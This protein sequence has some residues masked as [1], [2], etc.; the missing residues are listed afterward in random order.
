MENNNVIKVSIIQITRPSN[1]L[2]SLTI[3][4]RGRYS[5]I[6]LGFKN[7]GKYFFAHCF[8]SLKCPIFN[9][10]QNLKTCDEER[11]NY[12]FL[13]FRV[14]DI[15]KDQLR[16]VDLSMSRTPCSILFPASHGYGLASK[17]LLHFLIDRHN[18]I[19]KMLSTEKKM[20]LESVACA[21]IIDSSMLVSVD[22]Q[23]LHLALVANSQ[24][25]FGVGDSKMDCAKWTLNECGLEDVIVERQVLENDSLMTS[26]I[27]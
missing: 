2:W 12:F 1:I 18:S 27:F 14:G 5:T 6:R 22:G 15:I 19:L 23:D 24:Y 7:S 13:E 26:F 3:V 17:V 20:A 8:A 11:N 16:D 9:V 10:V 4:T 25:N 21:D